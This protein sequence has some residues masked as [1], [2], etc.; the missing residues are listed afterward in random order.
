[1]KALLLKEYMKLE[2]GSAGVHRF[3]VE[4]CLHREFRSFAR[5]AAHERA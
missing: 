5:T 4:L 3:A 1:M 2:L